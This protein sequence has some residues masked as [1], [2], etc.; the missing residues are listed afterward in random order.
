MK[1]IRAQ[2]AP[3]RGQTNS[4]GSV[5]ASVSAVAFDA[6]GTLFNFTEPD[7]VGL[8]INFGER[9]LRFKRLAKSQ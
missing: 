2:S 3:I 1:I 9:S 8:I 6:Y 4:V 5:A 7:F